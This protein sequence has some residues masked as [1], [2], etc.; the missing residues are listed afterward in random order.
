MAQGTTSWAEQGLFSTCRNR[1]APSAH[2]Y[3]IQVC[4]IVVCS[5]HYNSIVQYLKVQYSI[6]IS[7]SLSLSTYIYIYVYTYMCIHTII[8]VYMYIHVY[9][10]LS[11]YIY[12]YVYV[13]IYIYIQRDIYV[14]QYYSFVP[15]PRGSPGGRKLSTRRLQS[16][17]I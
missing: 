15:W 3:C 5:M 17:L 16:N 11:L 14:Y 7:L 4:V 1:V 13:Y 8:C 10:S 2:S 6:L 9:I 12:I